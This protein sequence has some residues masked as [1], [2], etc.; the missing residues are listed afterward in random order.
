MNDK[1]RNNAGTIQPYTDCPRCHASNDA[2][3]RTMCRPGDDD[4]P[5]TADEDWDKA[6]AILNRATAAQAIEDDA[7]ERNSGSSVQES[8]PWRVGTHNG[9]PSLYSDDFTHDVTLSIHGDFESDEQRAAYAEELAR[10][11]NTVLP[12]SFDQNAKDAARYRYLRAA[13]RPGDITVTEWERPTLTA[14]K[15]IAGEKLDAA[16]DAK[17]SQGREVKP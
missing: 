9:R 10:R 11:L 17:L 7:N 3:A 2:E 1:T 16:I 12:M 6:L 8:G 4:C 15:H 14:G 13:E 5:M